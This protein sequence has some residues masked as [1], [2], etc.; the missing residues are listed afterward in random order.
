VLYQYPLFWIS[1][2]ILVYFTE[3][4]V[5]EGLLDYL[6]KHSMELARQ[7]YKISYIFKYLLLLSFTI[8]AWYQVLAGRQHGK[9]Q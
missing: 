8:G 9:Y 3:T 1:A 6:I 2:G 5:I 4:L 7:A